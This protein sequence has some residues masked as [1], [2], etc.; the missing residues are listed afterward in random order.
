MI[1]R[2]GYDCFCLYLA[3]QRHFSSTYDFFKYNG[4]VSASVDSYKKRNDFFS[5]EKMAKIIPGPER[6]DFL[7]AHFIENPSEWIRNMSKVKY[8]EWKNKMAGLPGI[9]KTDLQFIYMEGMAAA[10][11]V[12]N[13]IPLI[14]KYVINKEI[15]IESVVILDSIYPFID[16][17]KE[18]VSVPFMWNEYITKLIKYRPFIQQRIDNN[19][20]C[21]KIQLGQYYYE[22]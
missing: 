3:L 1:T 11:K 10:F 6:V 18:E 7:I 21:T 22:I 12:N 13:D 17:H 20:S 15:S 9:F 8:D 4:R 16:R 14:H 19:L 5:F 2:E